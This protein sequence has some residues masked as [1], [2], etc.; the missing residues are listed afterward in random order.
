MV[1]S[2]FAW[3]LLTYIRWE[4][5]TNSFIDSGVVLAMLMRTLARDFLIA[6][7]VDDCNEIYGPCTK[8]TMMLFWRHASFFVLRIESVIFNLSSKQWRKNVQTQ[9]TA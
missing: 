6:A 8:L 4:I 3:H 5:R 9:L 1:V 2:N 7:R